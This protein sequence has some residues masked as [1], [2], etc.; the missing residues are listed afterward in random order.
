MYVKFNNSIN[1]FTVSNVI[2]LLYIIIETVLHYTVNDWCE[3]LLLWF[4]LIL[5]ISIQIIILNVFIVLKFLCIP[6]KRIV[7]VIF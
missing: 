1:T 2:I 7:N 5:L 3:E 6:S 4:T